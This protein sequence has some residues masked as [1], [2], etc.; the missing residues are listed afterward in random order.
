MGKG[1]CAVDLFCGTGGLSLGLQQA[2]V[3]VTAGIDIEKRCQY[4]YETNIKAKFVL[5]DINK[6]DGKRLKKLWAEG[7]LRLLA[8][9]APCQ[10]F[11]SQRRGA[12][13]SEDKN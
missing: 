3:Q 10:P 11:S 5:A 12:K 7:D 9:C 4:P 2:G 1:I 13:P 6:V 8:G